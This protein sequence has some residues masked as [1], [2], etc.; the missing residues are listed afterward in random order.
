MK[1]IPL[2]LQDEWVKII[3]ETANDVCQMKGWA[4]KLHENEVIPIIMALYI[5]QKVMKK[6]GGQRNDEVFCQREIRGQ[7]SNP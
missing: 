4:N 5:I 7:A 3:K 2:Y 1:K 6:R